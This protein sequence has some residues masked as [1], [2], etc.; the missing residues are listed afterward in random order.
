MGPAL[1]LLKNVLA[2][3]C[4]GNHCQDKAKHGSPT[5]DQL[6]CCTLQAALAVSYMLLSICC[7]PA[8]SNVLRQ[9][10]GGKRTILADGSGAV[11]GLHPGL[12][13]TWNRIASATPTS[14]PNSSVSLFS[15]GEVSTSSPFPILSSYLSTPWRSRAG[16]SVFYTNRMV[17][18]NRL[19]TP[20]MTQACMP[21]RLMLQS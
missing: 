16:C 12:V 7:F 14:V 10:P 18:T 5:V 4:K 13:Y 3:L 20:R 15:S 8:V 19:C 1:N 21:A 9:L 6:R 11:T 17:I 2:G